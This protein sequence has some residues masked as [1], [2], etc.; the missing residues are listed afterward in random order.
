MDISWGCRAS[1]CLPCCFCLSYHGLKVAAASLAIM[2][3][4]KGGKGGEGFQGYTLWICA[5][6]SGKKKLAK[7]C[8]KRRFT[9][10]GLETGALN[11]H[12]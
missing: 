6:L 12:I 1:F 8:P 2:S 10:H 11:I 7:W 9:F 3:A 4:F 5:F